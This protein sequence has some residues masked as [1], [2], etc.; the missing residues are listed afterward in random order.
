MFWT[1]IGYTCIVYWHALIVLGTLIGG[2][3]GLIEVNEHDGWSAVLRGC[4]G[5]LFILVSF[6]YAFMLAYYNMG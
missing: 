3:C 4:G 2:I 5:I 6:G 1:T